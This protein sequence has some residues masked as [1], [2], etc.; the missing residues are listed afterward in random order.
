MNFGAL[1]HELESLPPEQQDKLSAFLITLRMKRDGML[2]EISRRIDDPES[3]NWVS[4]ERVK[5]EEDSGS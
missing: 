2:A 1:Q 3:S 4:W 5:N